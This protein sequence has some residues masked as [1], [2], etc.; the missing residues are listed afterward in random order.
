MLIFYAKFPIL[1]RMTTKNL[2]I[3][4]GPHGLCSSYFYFHSFLT[5]W[6]PFPQISLCSNLVGPPVGSQRQKCFLFWIYMSGNLLLSFPPDW[7]SWFSQAFAQ[8]SP[9]QWR[10]PWPFYFPLSLAPFTVQ[11]LSM[12]NSFVTPWTVARRA[13]LAMGFP[14][15]EYWSGLLF[16]SP[17]HLSDPGIKP[18]SLHW[19]AGSL[20]LSLTHLMGAPISPQCTVI[21]PKVLI[22]V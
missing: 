14:R 7:L 12:S 6:T 20:P 2:T 1:L 4:S 16:P 17:G 9:F 5:Y 21:F 22:L 19:Q 15:Q 11:R 18:A 10:L 8:M 13:P 3:V